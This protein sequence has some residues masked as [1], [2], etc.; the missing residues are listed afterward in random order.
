M[1]PVSNPAD[2]LKGYITAI[3]PAAQKARRLSRRVLAPLLACALALVCALTAAATLNARS[4]ARHGVDAQ[5]EAI[6]RAAVAALDRSG[7]T[8]PVA[9]VA[10]ASGGSLTTR[11]ADEPLPGGRALHDRGRPLASEHTIPDLP[12]PKPP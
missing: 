12:P 8:S 3:P 10:R 1:R 9:S 6:H 4:A 11:P 7:H 5:A 2:T